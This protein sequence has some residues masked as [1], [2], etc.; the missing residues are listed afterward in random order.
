MNTKYAP[1]SIR[2]REFLKVGSAAAVA[3]AA[4]NL[5]ADTASPAATDTLPTR[6]SV[7]FAGGAIDFDHNFDRA[8]VSLLAGPAMPVGDPRFLHESAKVTILGVWRTKENQ[9]SPLTLGVNAYY[10]TRMYSNGDVVFYAWRQTTLTGRMARRQASFVIPVDDAG[11]RIELESSI[12]AN[13]SSLLD[14]VRSRIS[15]PDATVPSQ[16]RDR[17]V[18]SAEPN[19]VTLSIGIEREL[20]KLNRGMYVIALLPA[21]AQSPEWQ[22]IRFSPW[23]LK[24]EDGP[25]S[26]MGILGDSAVPFDYVVLD[27]DYA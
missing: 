20:A 18:I 11:L 5:F 24:S 7:A 27:V 25:V 15:T 1:K 19:V 3:F 23:N 26:A 14:S 8:G 17:A 22:A 2:R 4:R 9:K 6:L 13:R 16:P 10:P 21:K 12:P